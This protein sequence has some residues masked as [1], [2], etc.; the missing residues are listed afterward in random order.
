MSAELI[1]ILLN[2]L[3]PNT[4]IV[5]DSQ[6]KLEKCNPNPEFPLLLGQIICESQNHPKQLDLIAVVALAKCIK[7]NYKYND[8]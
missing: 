3:E 5:K 7:F 6:L 1:Q 4:E 2:T 8:M